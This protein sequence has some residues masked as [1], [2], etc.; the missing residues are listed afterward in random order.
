MMMTSGGSDG[1]ANNNICLIEMRFEYDVRFL[2][3]FIPDRDEDDD[4]AGKTDARWPSECGVD[5]AQTRKQHVLSR[6]STSRIALLLLFH[7]VALT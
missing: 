1:N 5:A 4:R 2:F 6:R 7:L 3:L